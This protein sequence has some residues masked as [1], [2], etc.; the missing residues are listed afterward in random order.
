M[1]SYGFIKE[2]I[3]KEHT[4][5]PAYVFDLDKM[6]EFVKKVQSCLGESTQLCYAMKANP[7]LTGPMMW[8]L[9]LKC[10]HRVNFEFVSVLV[11]RWRELFFRVCIRTLKIWNMY[12]LHM[13]ERECIL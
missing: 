3:E 12:F 8:F 4:P 5:T 6:K 13:E 11:C 9:H 1:S 10:A 2:L 7:F